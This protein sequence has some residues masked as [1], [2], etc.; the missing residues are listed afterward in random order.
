MAGGSIL[1]SLEVAIPIK[2]QA[3]RMILRHFRSQHA[4]KMTS[5]SSQSQLGQGEVCG[6]GWEETQI[7]FHLEMEPVFQRKLLL[8]FQ[9]PGSSGRLLKP[10]VP[11]WCNGHLNP[12]EKVS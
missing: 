5:T 7:Q 6:L 12:G 4:S 11:S 9:S 2:L 8:S 3:W 1:T 10:Q